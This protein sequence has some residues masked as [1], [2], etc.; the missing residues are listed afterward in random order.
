L[1]LKSELVFDGDAG[2]TEPNDST[3]RTG[4]EWSNT[5]HVNSWLSAE[6]DAAF[7]KARFDST[8]PP[9]DL[10]CGDAAPSHPCA[11]PIAV[12]GRYIP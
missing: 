10:G 11:A 12:V 8:A 7:A 9:D 4:I 2:V 6:L 3:T 5:Y 1:K